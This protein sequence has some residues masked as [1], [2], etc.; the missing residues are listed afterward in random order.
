MN[1][2]I[3]RGTHEIG[4]TCIELTSGD[5]RLI[6]DLGM[7]L[8]DDR[9]DRFSM[10]DKGE[11]VAE[12]IDQ[13][14]LPNIPD[15]YRKSR[16]KNTYLVLSHAHQ[17]HYGFAHFI[18]S[19]IPVYMTKGTKS[20]LE[21]SEIFLPFSH[22]IKNT[23]EL[24]VWKTID[25]GSFRVTAYLVDHSAPDAVALLVEADGKRLYYSG[26][27]R[28]TGRKKKLFDSIIKRPPP[29]IDCLLLEGTMMGRSKQLYNTETAVEVKLMNLFKKKNNLALIFASG[30]NIDRLVSIYRAV[31][32]SDSILV[33]DLYTAYVLHKLQ[34]IS[35][36]LPQHNWEN[37][38]IKFWKSHADKISESGNLEFL[39]AANKSKIKIEEIVEKRE[40]IIMIA[41]SNRLFGIVLKNLPNLEG[42]EMIWS[43]WQGY[44]TEDNIVRQY[45]ESN[46]VP[47]KEIHTSGHA[48]IDDLKLFA[49]A[50]NPKTLI[51]I[52]TFEPEKYAE[53]FENVQVLN[54][55][56]L[57]QI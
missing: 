22:E 11:T 19:S 18:D 21:V 40:Q 23:Q 4:G 7:P 12:L 24:P 8:V 1:L 50:L 35:D 51:P 2:T 38:R 53:H 36:S 37:V 27:F 34:N 57:L 5:D 44:L 16:Q 41:R 48:S 46:G 33:I 6:L 56:E 49:N 3:H 55:G 28:A 26:D 20:I 9:G 30:Q 14:V 29:D 15:L 43:L 13:K 47:L 42:L 32:A 10:Q 52:H 25:V 39:Y 45:C 54:D 17:D 31:S